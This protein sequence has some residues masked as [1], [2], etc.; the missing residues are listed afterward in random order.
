LWPSTQII[1]VSIPSTSYTTSSFSTFS[2]TTTIASAFSGSCGDSVAI[3]RMQSSSY[4]EVMLRLNPMPSYAAG[5]SFSVSTCN[6]PSTSWDTVIA[7]FKCIPSGNGVKGSVISC[8]CAGNDD[9]CTN[10]GSTAIVPYDSGY[11][12][13]VA[14]TGYYSRYGSFRLTLS[15][16]S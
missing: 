7:V 1:D 5:T 2:Y 15:G 16:T 9:A 6:F 12:Y 8:T 13:Y 11:D 10:A 3:S 14:V 4:K